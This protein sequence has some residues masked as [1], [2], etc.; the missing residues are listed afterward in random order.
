[1]KAIIKDLEAKLRS[2]RRHRRVN[3]HGPA[4]TAAETLRQNN[5]AI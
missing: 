2:N 3:Q 4:V 1:M 5:C